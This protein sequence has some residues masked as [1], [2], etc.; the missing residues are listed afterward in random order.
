[1]R[2][3]SHRFAISFHRQQR[4]ESQIRS[5][6]DDIPGLGSHR[7]KQLLSHFHSIDY[8]RIA[9]IEELCLAPGIGTHIAGEICNYFHPAN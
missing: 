7:Q 9:T 6:L 4:S 3:E 1:V 5:R 8:I 2:D